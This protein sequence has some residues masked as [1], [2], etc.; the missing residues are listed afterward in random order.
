MGCHVLQPGQQISAYNNGAEPVMI[1]GSVLSSLPFYATQKE[2]LP[3]ML[4][5]EGARVDP[6]WLMKFLKDPS[7]MQANEKPM[8]PSSPSASSSPSSS[9]AASD[10]PGAKP[11]AAT[12]N[13]QSNGKLLPQWGL[14]RNGIRP[15]IQVHMPT[16]NF[17]PNELRVLVRF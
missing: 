13:D 2:F 12:A 9:P 3:P 8:T 6:D 5:S 4:T 11:A 10:S 1:T 14:N 15:Y 16:F 7:L 17:S